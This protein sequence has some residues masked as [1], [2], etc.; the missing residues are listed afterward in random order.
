MD[1]Q[2]QKIG[3]LMLKQATK[4]VLLRVTV[5]GLKPGIHGMHFHEKGVCNH[6]HKFLDA[7]GHI[8]PENKPHGF[9]HPEGP[10]A[11]NL[12]NL[13]VSLAGTA[14]V[15]LY[16]ELVSIYGSNNKP[17]LLDQDGSTLIIH[18]NEDDH[19]TQPIGGSGDRI[20]CSVIKK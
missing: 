1:I 6:T 18:A 2:G 13:I 12:P 4:G 8:S 19:I 11:G 7:K 16:T 10:H 5:S 14:E 15:E 3:D 9:L 17:A 20:A